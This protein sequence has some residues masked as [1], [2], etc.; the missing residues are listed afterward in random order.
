MEH[1]T[2]GPLPGRYDE[3]LDYPTGL[4]ITANVGAE[5][6]DIFRRSTN[7]KWTLRKEGRKVLTR[8]N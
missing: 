5:V 7:E 4:L 2:T 3:V 1:L 8:R 6:H